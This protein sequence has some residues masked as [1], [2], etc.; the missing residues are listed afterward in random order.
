[1]VFRD[2]IGDGDSSTRVDG[3]VTGGRDLR[4]VVA[5]VAVVAAF[6]GFLWLIG[7]RGDAGVAAP[8]TTDPSSI[9]D[10]ATTAISIEPP[11]PLEPL[12]GEVSGYQLFYGGDAPLQRLD[13]DTGELSLFGLRAHPVLVTGPSLVLYQE[14]G[15]LIGW[16]PLDDPGEQVQTW[17]R[18][19]LA[20]GNPPGSLWLL[21]P[22]VDEQHPSGAPVGIGTWK[23]VETTSNRMES[24]LPGDQWD[25]VTSA[26]HGD[27]ALGGAVGLFRPGPGLSSRPNGVHLMDGD[28][29]RR[30][31]DGRVLIGG[32]SGLLLTGTCGPE[33]PCDLSWFDLG[34]ETGVERRLPT[35]R[36][37]VARLAGGGAWVHSVGWD[38]TSELLQLDTGRV[39]HN[40]WATERPAI[41]PDGRWLAHLADGAV[42]ITD[43]E[44][45]QAAVIDGFELDGSGS[46]LFVAAAG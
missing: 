45:D 39:I 4:P 19:L 18:V 9:D 26:V 41:S 29:F 24:T 44:R 28:G 35:V 11:E 31:T 3:R 15:G 23:L 12:L 46:L 6:L 13:L 37:R 14:S 36:P 8:T 40:D 1:M 5:L 25:E 20:E 38:G 43:L 16:V 32:T 34:T 7:D 42:V 30:L 33:G 21:D 27:P 22:A 10:S 2:P 17:K